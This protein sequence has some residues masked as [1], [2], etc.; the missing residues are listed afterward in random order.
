MPIKKIFFLLIF[1]FSIF[2]QNKMLI[3][4]DLSQTDHLK[5]YGITFHALEQGLKAD[6]LLNYRGGSFL[7][8]YSR[9]IENECRIE[10]VSFTTLTTSEA[11]SIYALVQSNDQNMDVVRLEKAPKIGVYVP[12]GFQPWDDAVTLVLEYA[13]IPY[14]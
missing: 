2:A 11:T 8:D 5:A 7:L 1:S 9:P 13:K 4:M 3:Q 10:G 14:D 6:W 12:P